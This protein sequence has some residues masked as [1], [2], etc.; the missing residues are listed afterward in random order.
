MTK[1]RELKNFDEIA[2]RLIH[3]S[4]DEVKARCPSFAPTFDANLGLRISRAAASYGSPARQCGVGVS[5]ECESAL[6][7]GIP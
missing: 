6:A 4:Q 5:N 3:V 2:Q 7:D 1:N